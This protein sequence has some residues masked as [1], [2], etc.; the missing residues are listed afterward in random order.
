MLWAK[1]SLPNMDYS[2]LGHILQEIKTVAGLCKGSFSCV[3]R[4]GN[5][6]V[7]SLTKFVKSI[8]DNVIWIEDSPPALELEALFFDVN[9]SLVN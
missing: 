3:R 8:S 5:S 1:L 9:V 7:H 4:F 2:W 6:V